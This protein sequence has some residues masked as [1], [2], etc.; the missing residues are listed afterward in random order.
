M[1]KITLHPYQSEGKAKIYHEWG[2]GA[3]N[4]L[5]ICPTGG[6]KSVVTSDIILDGVN[7]NIQQVV[8][9]HRNELVSQ[10]SMHIANRGISHRVVGSTSTVSQIV[11][12]HRR[13]HNRSFVNPSARTAVVGV[14]T[15]MARGEQLAP[16]FAQ[17]ER[18][19]LDEAHHLLRSN[20]WG[21]AVTMMPNAHGLGVTATPCR[22]DGQGLGRE[23]DGVFDAMVLGPTMRELIGWGNLSDYE[24]VCPESDITNYL[25]DDDLGASGDFTDKK[26][27]AAAEKSRIVGDVIENYIKFA[28][29]R[30][31]IVFATDIETGNKIA[32]KFNAA[33]ISAANLS[34]KTP[35]AVREKYI[36]DFK[37]GN[38][39][40]LI[41]VDLFDEG[42]DVPACDVVIMARPTASLGKF[43]Q[44]VGR[45]LRF[46]IGKIALIID[47]VGNIK[48]HGL[49][50]K[51]RIWTLSRRD[52]RAK[53]APD[54]DDIPI[55]VCKSCTRPYERFHPICPHCGAAPPLPKPAERSI[56]VVDGD[57]ILLD[58]ATLERMRA[59]TVL[60][61]PTDIAERV[62]AVAGDIAA[63]GVANRQREKIAS[64]RALSDSIAQWAGIERAKG[65]SD[66]ELYRRFYLAVGADVLS[67]L[68]ADRTR[69]EYESLTEIVR[70]WYERVC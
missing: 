37:T 67:V 42:F 34:S 2:C 62:G 60:E 41:N 31:A 38:L 25:T 16:W 68:S 57:L 14:D 39:L 45:A 40:V 28:N 64:Q 20:K 30:K 61:S 24:I 29:G 44:M 27:K 52:K 15:L 63:K 8:M 12:Q 56:E 5:Y 11:R 21:K 50:S 55:T 35:T 48:R 43:M 19:I 18:W 33:G 65:K 1:Q 58:R 53:K 59:G 7:S 22:A 46:V 69:Q 36:N 47:H 54:P 6:G 23:Y 32:A 51:H 26:L 9:A 49:P 4:V 17:T 10:M 66:S 70:G 3:Q 13:T